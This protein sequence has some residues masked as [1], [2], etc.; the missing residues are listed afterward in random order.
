[1]NL[2]LALLV[3]AEFVLIAFAAVFFLSSR[4]EQKREQ[5]LDTFARHLP[6]R[7]NKLVNPF[8]DEYEFSWKKSFER[9]IEGVS[10]LHLLGGMA[11]ILAL[12]LIIGFRGGALQGG[13]ALAFGMLA[14]WLALL[15]RKRR[16][17]LRIR[18]Q[19]PVFVD[20]IQRSLT[21]G[22]A[23]E[24]ALRS[25]TLDTETPLRE[26]LDEIVRGVDAGSGLAQALHR[27]STKYEIHELSLF[28]LAIHI[29]YNHGSNPKPLLDNVAAMVRRNEQ[30][31]HELA[32]MTGETRISA[33]VLGMLPV[34]IVAY[35]H[36]GNP[37]YIGSM[38]ADDSG[39]WM[40]IAAVTLQITGVLVLWRMMRSLDA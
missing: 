37:A 24:W 39:R 36:F 5:M 22:K 6:Q 7:R 20:L 26:V 31:R 9:L 4:R 1:M 29:S 19:I 8:A 30:M 34:V 2:G 27:A 12:T 15:E 21:A 14:G 11:A 32:A 38:I 18:L 40:L 10:R 28:A 35:L 25:A 3:L 16:L 13:I 33:W 23:V 17:K